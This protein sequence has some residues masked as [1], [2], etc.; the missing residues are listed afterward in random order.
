MKC[1]QA[2]AHVCARVEF[3]QNLCYALHN[4]VFF[5]EIPGAWDM[6]FFLAI[7]KFFLIGHTPVYNILFSPT[8]TS[9]THLSLDLPLILVLKTGIIPTWGYHCIPRTLYSARCMKNSQ[10]MFCLQI[11]FWLLSRPGVN[12]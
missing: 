4:H 1:A 11:I 2:L 3:S 10:E 9:F 7:Q 12:I 8:K 5:Q 6:G